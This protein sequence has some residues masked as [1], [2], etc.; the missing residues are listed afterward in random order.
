MHS[1]RIVL[2]ISSLMTA[3]CREAG[4]A[5]PAV[6]PAKVEPVSAEANVLTITL[7]PEARQRLGVATVE[8]A[9]RSSSAIRLTTGEV[10]N[11]P[12]GASDVP[13]ISTSDFAALAGRQAAADAELHRARAALTLAQQ[14]AQRADALLSEEAGS[15]RVRDEAVAQ[16]A[17]AEAALA[18]ARA[19]RE[20][21]G[22]DP[23]AIHGKTTLWVRVP[24]IAT[25]LS[26]L[27]A[28]QPAYIGVPGADAP[29]RKALPVRTLPT[30]NP[31]AGTTDIYYRFDNDDQAYRLGQRVAVAV[32]LKGSAQGLAIPAAAVVSD[33]H[34]GAW[35]YR[36]V[37]ERHYQRQRV[38]VARRD[39]DDLILARGLAAGD[40]IV[41]AGAAELF[42]YE[43]GIGR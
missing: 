16:R 13:T 21:L 24:V 32:P 7:T 38:E 36:Q 5:A 6:S 34:G 19:Q 20:L 29:T 39:G 23:A 2:V 33:I 40:E 8:V 26:R 4:T 1:L 9:M 31:A 35:V 18:A 42:G 3:A 27:S 30:A 43:F 28:D 10:V 14:M 22:P 25:D 11:A 15:A 37:D 12:I 41:T 17:A